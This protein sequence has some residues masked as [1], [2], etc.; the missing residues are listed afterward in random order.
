MESEEDKLVAAVAD[1][2]VAAIN[3][4]VDCVR[5]LFEH[6]VPTE[7]AACI[8]DL[9]EVIHVEDGKREGEAARIGECGVLRNAV[10]KL[11][12]VVCAREEIA[13]RLVL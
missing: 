11:M 4:R 13:A 9:F 1:E 6:L 7:M 10:R 2:D 5:D 12:A 3:A 8:V